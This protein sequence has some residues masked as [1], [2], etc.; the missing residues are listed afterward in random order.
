MP[1]AV[2]R[3]ERVKED[4]DYTLTRVWVNDSVEA[5]ALSARELC[6][7]PQERRR[8]ERL[9]DDIADLLQAKKESGLV[10]GEEAADR[11]GGCAQ[12]HM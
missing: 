1:R 2:R 6:H 10:W 12:C 4:V 7:F 3:S 5:V 8:R 9:A 11:Q